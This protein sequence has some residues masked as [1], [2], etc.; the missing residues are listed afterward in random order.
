MTRAD[1]QQIAEERAKD[2]QALIAASQWSGAFYLAGYA[3]ECGL[4][5]CVLR[6]LSAMPELIFLE[7]RFS[8]KCWTDNLE[9]LVELADLVSA[10]AGAVAVNATLGTNWQTVGEWSEQDRYRMKTETQARELVIAVTD[11]ASG[12][13]SWIKGHW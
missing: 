9:D 5:S 12:V 13:L 7:K 3:V 10:R 1:W 8:E 2:A 6:R 11:N 4:K